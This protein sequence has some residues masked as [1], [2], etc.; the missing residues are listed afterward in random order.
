M[1]NNFVI[2]MFS[3]DKFSIP[4]E[5]YTRL[6]AVQGGGLINI[7][8]F[9]GAI[10]FSSI[11]SIV[12]ASQIDRSNLKDGF[13]H[14]GT[15]VAR[16]FGTWVDANNPDV[17]IDFKYYPEVAKD[18]I[19]ISLEEVDEYNKNLLENKKNSGTQ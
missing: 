13:L 6:K 15:P 9:G 4:E 2:K 19:F 10:N 18:Q 17:K 8:S 11:E 16:R 7:P 14:D 12:P 1:N 3:G 5:T